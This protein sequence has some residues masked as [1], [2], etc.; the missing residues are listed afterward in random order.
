MSSCSIK[1][2]HAPTLTS[3]AAPPQSRIRRRHGRSEGPLLRLGIDQ[4]LSLH[5][6]EDLDDV[7][8]G[9]VQSMSVRADSQ[10]G[11]IEVTGIP[12]CRLES[13]SPSHKPAKSLKDFV[14]A[15]RR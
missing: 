11:I 9:M 7:S 3:C 4:R 13:R 5:E 14:Q 12:R 10:S 15:K 2:Q 6:A 1:D 8:N